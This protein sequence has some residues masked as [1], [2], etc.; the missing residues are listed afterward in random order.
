MHPRK[1]TEQHLCRVAHRFVV[2]YD[3][4][5]V[6]VWD[7]ATGRSPGSRPTRADCRHHAFWSTAAPW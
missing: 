1:V 7:L 6:L 5:E 2:G 3:D 4:G